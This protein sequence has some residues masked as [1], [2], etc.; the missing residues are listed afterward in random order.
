MN[1]VQLKKWLWIVLVLILSLF[2]LFYVITKI[3]S[4]KKEKSEKQRTEIQN[5]N[6]TESSEKAKSTALPSVYTEYYTLKK[7]EEPIRVII[8]S[9]YKKYELYGGGKQYYCQ[10]QNRKKAI[11]GGGNC[12][13]NDNPHATYADISYYNEEI[14]VMCKQIK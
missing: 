9:G 10:P 8:K 3:K 13:T 6:K 7:G 14:T 12:V 4:N 5:K 1:D 11:W 2:F